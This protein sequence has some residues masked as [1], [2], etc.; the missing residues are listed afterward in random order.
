MAS[1]SRRDFLKVLAMVPL[2]PLVHASPEV[3]LQTRKIYLRTVLIAGFQYYDGY[4]IFDQLVVGDELELR[5]QPDNPYD[6]KAIEVYTR[7]GH[8]LGYI[9]RIANP[10]P[11]A[12]AD[13]NIAIGAE[14]SGLRSPD[15]YYKPIKM[16]LYM[17]IL[18]EA[19]DAI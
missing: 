9:P 10:I 15:E 18:A 19:P 7:D 8:K 16:Q 2:S 13:Q 3:R 4:D 17:I 11:A 12:L 6:D 1:I 14:I 5:R